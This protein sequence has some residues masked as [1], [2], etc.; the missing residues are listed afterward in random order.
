MNNIQKAFKTKSNLR[1]MADG[2]PVLEPEDLGTGAAA[3]TAALL[4]N[5][6]SALDAAID[7]AERGEDPP[8]PPK[9]DPAVLRTFARGGPVKGPGGP[10]DDKIPAML[11]DGEYVLPADTVDAVGKHKLDALRNATHSFK[12]NAQGMANGGLLD[13]EGVRAGLRGALQ[14]AAIPFDTATM[15]VASA[16]ANDIGNRLLP[17]GPSGALPVAPPKI[18]PGSTNSGSASTAPN[19]LHGGPSAVGAPPADSYQSRRLS[20]LGISA[21]VQNSLAVDEA[22]RNELFGTGSRTGTQGA[23][24]PMSGPVNLGS[25]GGD[26]NIYGSASKPGGRMDTFTGVGASASPNAPAGPSLMDDVRKGLADLGNTRGGA[27]FTA[28]SNAQDINSRFDKQAELI[29]KTFTSDKAKGNLAKNLSQLEVNRA[30]A[31]GD[32][33]QLGLQARGQDVTASN[34]AL[35]ARMSGLSTLGGLAERE[36]ATTA[37]GRAAQFKAAQDAQAQSLEQQEK[38]VA[39]LRESAVARYGKDD[40]KAQQFLSFIQSAGPELTGGL[41][42]LTGEARSNAF[43]DMF[44]RFEQND[45]LNLGRKQ[46]SVYDPIKSKRTLEAP[47]LL[48]MD[49][50]D[51]A[52]GLV[53]RLFGADMG[54]VY[55]TD[56]GRVTQATEIPNDLRNDRTIRDQIADAKR[57][58]KLRSLQDDRR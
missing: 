8:P 23:Q 10:T 55:E 24:R 19:P 3:Q 30:R 51:G 16:V 58:G 42:G 48:K 12:N 39:D 34:A 11:S 18:M 54:Q 1:K 25:Y 44:A 36:A 2:G 15:G 14:G 56:A 20:E 13:D 6:P 31:L 53:G 5:R 57:R 22:G 47:D 28:P 32:D 46:S 35:Q 49:L 33:A 50:V 41:A 29:S 4:K 37:A 9:P 52:Q 43:E 26:S 45:A 38:G 7:A 27:G 21:P 40:P 17:P